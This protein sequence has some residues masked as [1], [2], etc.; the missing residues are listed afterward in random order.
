MPTRIGTT[1]G[2]C[3]SIQR[4]ILTPIQRVILTPIQSV[5]LTPI[6]RV[7]LTPIQRVILRHFFSLSMEAWVLILSS[8]RCVL[9]CIKSWKIYK[10]YQLQQIKKNGF[11][12]QN[13]LKTFISLLE[14]P[15]LEFFIN[16]D[17]KPTPQV[18]QFFTMTPPH[19]FTISHSSIL[20]R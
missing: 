5:I 15:I 2:D 20:T 12:F 4:V 14:S 13:E 3:K 19:N 10:N 7:I 11:S 18:F 17:P 8:S 1:P 16:R 9:L 6:Q